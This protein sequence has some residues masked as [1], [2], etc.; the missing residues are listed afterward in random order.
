MSPGALHY[1]M[2]MLAPD[3]YALWD[4]FVDEHAQGHLLQ[5]W[6][7]GELKASG[8]WQPLR[9]ALFDDDTHTIVAATQV[10]LRVVPFVPSR[11]VN[12]AYIPR[13]PVIHWAQAEVCEVFFLLLHRFL[14]RQ[15]AIALRLEPA[16]PLETPEG[17]VLV[18]RLM[19]QRMHPEHAIQPLRT[20]MLDLEPS[21][22]MLLAHM[23]E[24]WRYNV[25]LAARKGVT[26]RVAE[27]PADVCAWYR[28]LRMTSE[29]DNF[30]IHE[31]A[32][33]EHVWNLMKPN[34]EARLFLAEHEGRLLA[35]I[36]VGLFAR[37]AI[38]LFGASGNEERQ[39]MPNYALQWEAIRWAKQQG[40][41]LYDFWG[42]PETDDESEAMS[43]VYRFK[44]GWGGRIVQFPGCYEIVYR[45]L[46]MHLVRRFM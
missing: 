6:H 1:S 25:R 17:E 38:Y 29:R 41:L 37:Q 13:G 12:L 15:G 4:R 8:H 5:S 45:P 39:L 2:H 43:G 34:D 19:T 9:L 11:I 10:L 3:Q 24:K 36:F 30:G 40:A 23:K 26:V 20:I 22:E 28:L 31:Y 35:G 18:K 33:Y 16:Q 21:E 7:W 14:R 27:T 32:Y 42:I 46:A 44:R